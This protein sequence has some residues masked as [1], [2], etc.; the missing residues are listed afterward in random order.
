MELLRY[1]RGDGR[2]PFTEWLNALRDKAAAA[3][4]RIRLQRIEA[5]ISATAS[6]SAMA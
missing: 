5:D 3:R 6:R 2:E 4:I 1:Q